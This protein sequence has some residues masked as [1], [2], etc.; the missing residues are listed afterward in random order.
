MVTAWM[1]DHIVLS[2]AHEFPWSPILC[3]PC[4]PQ[5]SFGCSH[6]S[7]SWYIHAQRSHLHIKD[8]AIHVR[9]WWIMETVEHPAS[10][11][12]WAACLLQLAFPRETTQISH[13][14]NPSWTAQLLKKKKKYISRANIE[15]FSSCKLLGYER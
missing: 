15:T 13:G 9:V 8:P 10:T 14:R 4:I 6:N 2:F 11:I 12:S 3:R 1:D 7:G 5:K